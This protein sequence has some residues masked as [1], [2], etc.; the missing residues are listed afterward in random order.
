M[1]ISAFK[2]I[3]SW[4]NKTKPNKFLNKLNKLTK[5]SSKERIAVGISLFIFIFIFSYLIRPIYFDYDLKKN[6]LRAKINDT[7]KVDTN[8]NGK[9]NYTIFPSPRIIVKNAKF[10]FEKTSKDSIKIKT[11]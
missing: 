3:K 10:N 1:K 9:I 8:I 4:L 11:L 6:I 5:V 7:F 2:I